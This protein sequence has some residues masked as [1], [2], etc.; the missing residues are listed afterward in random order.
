MMLIQKY[1]IFGLKKFNF[2]LSFIKAEIYFENS[3][4]EYKVS[5]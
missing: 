1:L 4:M 5:L 2:L 3:V